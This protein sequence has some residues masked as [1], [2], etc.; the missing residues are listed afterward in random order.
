MFHAARVLAPDNMVLQG[1]SAVTVNQKQTGY[2]IIMWVSRFTQP[3]LN[4][5]AKSK[6][7]VVAHTTI[8]Y[9]A[10]P[11]ELDG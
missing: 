5:S 10:I 6:L 1:V 11:T 8:V 2:S 9:V 4:A 3:L 7:H